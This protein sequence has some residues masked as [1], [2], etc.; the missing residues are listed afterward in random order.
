M[1]YRRFT[2]DSKFFEK[3]QSKNND[4]QNNDIENVLFANV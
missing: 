1:F 4:N 3:F 2:F